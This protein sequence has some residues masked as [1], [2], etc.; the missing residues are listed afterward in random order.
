MAIIF[1]NS[2]KLTLNFELAGGFSFTQRIGGL[3]RVHSLVFRID[4]VDGQTGRT[5]AVFQV[6]NG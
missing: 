4:L 2:L 3:A 6:Q 5:V 1:F